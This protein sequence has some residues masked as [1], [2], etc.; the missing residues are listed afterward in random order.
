MRY[1]VRLAD[2]QQDQFLREA[3][4]V[5]EEHG[6]SVKG[7]LTIDGMTGKLRL[8][9][10]TVISKRSMERGLLQDTSVAFSNGKFACGVFLDL[11]KIY[12]I[13]VG[14]RIRKCKGKDIR[15]CGE[16]FEPACQYEVELHTLDATSGGDLVTIQGQH[17]VWHDSVF[18]AGLTKVE[19]IGLRLYTGLYA[20]KKHERAPIH[21]SMHSREHIHTSS[22]I[23]AHNPQCASVILILLAVK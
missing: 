15:Y 13:D 3:L 17:L 19:V 1:T 7:W 14:G 9:P 11:Q 18:R 23:Y 12:D 22:P 2:G 21:G 8:K 5:V 4:N 20:G 10:V 6:N 16:E